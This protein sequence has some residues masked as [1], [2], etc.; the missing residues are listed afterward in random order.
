MSF[1]G[2][3]TIWEAAKQEWTKHIC[4][5]LV[6]VIEEGFR[7]IYINCEKSIQSRNHEEDQVHGGVIT[8]F[9]ETL[10]N[11]PKWNQE[12]IDQEFERILSHEDCHEVLDDLIK[13]AFTSHILIL[14]SVN[15]SGKSN[16]KVEM[17][18]PSSK[19]FVH[20]VYIEAA[21]IFFRNPHLFAKYDDG[22]MDENTEYR[23][24]KNSARVETVLCQAV[25]E[26]IRKLMP[27]R[28]ILQAY[29]NP[30]QIQ[31]EMHPE[32][33]K[34]VEDIT[35]RVSP[36]SQRGL[37]N[38]LKN[39]IK[40][41]SEVIRDPEQQSRYRHTKEQHQSN[42]EEDNYRNS[43]EDDSNEDELPRHSRTHDYSIEDEE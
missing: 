17:H 19:R 25:E 14:S 33:L 18:I 1:R 5:L 6:P 41:T 34:E 38:I 42:S 23:Y 20:K 36:R 16:H 3:H 4:N 32:E 35:R 26:S 31:E 9:K 7:N 24:H 13:A 21:R 15:L 40:K 37:K 27:I 43:D 10:L 30:Q 29:M 28:T 12:I 2:E 39:Y 8:A 11:I 22:D